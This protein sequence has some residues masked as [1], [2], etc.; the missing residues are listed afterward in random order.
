MW[1]S[2]NS[3]VRTLAILSGA[4]AIA[5][6]G[7]ASASR[8]FDDRVT[9]TPDALYYQVRVLEIRGVGH[10][11]A[12]A[13]VF[14]GPLSA[15]LRARDPEHT[16]NDDW[17][18]YNEPFYERRWTVPLAGA[19]LYPLDGDRALL[20]VSLAGYVAALLAVFGLLLLRVRV[21]IAFAVTLATIF[22]PPLVD[23]S[24]YPLT[25][26]WGL[27]LETSAFAFAIL[28]LDRGRRWLLVWFG[29]VLL[30]AFTRDSAWI[31]ILAVGWLAWRQRSRA[32]LWLFGTGVAAVLPALLLFPV[33]VQN[34]L[35]LLVNDSDIASD[36]SWGFIVRNYPGAVFDLVHANGGF[37]RD[38]AWY[39]ALYLGGGIVLLAVLA[40]R[41][42]EGQRSTATKLMMAGAVLALLYVLAAPVFSAFRLELVLVPMA[43]YG[44]AVAAHIGLERLAARS[45]ASKPLVS[46]VSRH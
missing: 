28:T 31:P 3:V 26:S 33:P 11:A 35:A 20:D 39:A 10:D 17:V 12:M 32:A 29:V 6:I 38:G 23:H 2:D 7:C 40:A 4:V 44:I 41:G 36:P 34:L 19:A 16:G 5:L 43:A 14:E 27:A 9:W 42:G 21:A 30:L 22:L 13:K 46:R 8:A 25:D 45:Q 1:R 37:V 15:E 24:S 18:A